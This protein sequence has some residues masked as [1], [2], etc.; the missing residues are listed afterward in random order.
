MCFVSLLAQ[1]VAF[2]IKAQEY[3]SDQ[4]S[5]LNLRFSVTAQSG[6]ESVSAIKLLSLKPPKLSMKVRFLPLLCFFVV[7]S[8]TTSWFCR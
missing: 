7:L 6:D 5:L 3:V 1:S 2:T 4:A 8:V